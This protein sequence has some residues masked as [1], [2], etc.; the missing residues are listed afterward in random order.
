[1]VCWRSYGRGGRQKGGSRRP[2]KK[3]LMPHCSS[4]LVFSLKEKKRRNAPLHWLAYNQISG[5]EKRI[6]HAIL[7]S[8]MSSNIAEDGTVLLYS[9][10]IV[11]PLKAF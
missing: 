8:S 4:S 3:C 11:A 5:Q 2:V 7:Q 1:M 9:Q 6:M 10:P